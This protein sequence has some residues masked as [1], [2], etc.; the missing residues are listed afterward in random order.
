MIILV[1]SS[2]FPDKAE[3]TN[4]LTGQSLVPGIFLNVAGA[5][6]PPVGWTLVDIPE[7]PRSRIWLENQVV[8]LQE[9]IQY[10]HVLSVTC[11]PLAPDRIDCNGAILV[12]ER[13]RPDLPLWIEIRMN[14]DGPDL[15]DP[16]SLIAYNHPLVGCLAGS[17]GR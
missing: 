11:L 16:F 3:K 1:K 4:V 7:I 8:M 12:D 5:L 15:H 2:F 13:A 17:Q 6:S 9:R 14:P 10:E